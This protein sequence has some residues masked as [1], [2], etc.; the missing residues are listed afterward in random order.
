MLAPWLAEATLVGFEGETAKLY[1]ARDVA[2][3]GRIVIERKE[4]FAAALAEATG[5]S[6]RIEVEIEPEPEREVVE[7]SVDE[8]PDRSDRARA[9]LQQAHA[10]PDVPTS[11]EQIERAKQDPLVKAVLETFDGARIAKVE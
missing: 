11:N 7:E 10:E 9:I 2:E 1:F 8:T 5:R 3:H 6:I 4:K